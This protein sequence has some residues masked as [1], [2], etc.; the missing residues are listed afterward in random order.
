ML[1]SAVR[2]KSDTPRLAL[3]LFWLPSIGPESFTAPVLTT[4]EVPA[5]E[6]TEKSSQGAHA[7][8]PLVRMSFEA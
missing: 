3:G 1:E 8:N 7:L 6:A 5:P 2:S 4:P